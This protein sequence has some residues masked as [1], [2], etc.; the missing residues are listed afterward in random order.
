MAPKSDSVEG[1][2]LNFVN[3]Q[4]RPLNSQNAADSLQKFSLKKAAVQKALDTLADSGR[5][6]F[7]EYGKQKIYLARQDQFDIPNG[8]ELVRMKEENAKLQETLGEQKK[9]ISEVEGEIKALQS[10]LTLEQIHAKEAKMR[11]G[12]E[13][14]EDKLN[15]LR[16]G[17]TLVS[18]EERKV[19]EKMYLE[20]ISQWRRRK[21]MFKDLWDSITENSPKDLKE[22]KSLELNMMRILV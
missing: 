15:K 10:N 16:G 4:N 8:E 2:V 22:F 6:S 1:I 14:M 3:E 7:K 21:R 9:K 12:I 13:E 11:M 20:S 5:I 19:V 18:P 17:V